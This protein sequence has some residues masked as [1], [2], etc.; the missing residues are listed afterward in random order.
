MKKSLFIMALGAIALTSC[1]QDEIIEVQKDAISFAAITENAGRATI[2]NA[3]NLTEFNVSGIV[4]DG[5][6]YKTYFDKITMDDGTKEGSIYNSGYY[7]PMGNMDFYAYAP[8]ALTFVLGTPDAAANKTADKAAKIT[9]VTIADDATDQADIVYALSTNNA[10]PAAAAAPVDL[11]FRHALSQVD[12]KVKIA[13]NVAQAIKVVVNSITVKNLQ[14]TGV[15]SFPTTKTDT[16]TDG[17]GTWAISGE[18]KDY[19]VAPGWGALTNG[20]TGSTEAVTATAT[21]SMLLLP[22]TIEASTYSSGWSAK[23]LFILDADVYSV[24]GGTEVQLVSEPTYVPV[25]INWEEGKHY[26]YTFVYSAD[27]NGGKTDDNE[28]QLIP[29]QFTLSV[30][31]FAPTTPAETPVPLQ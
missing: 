13:S 14:G 28:D 7:W 6:T 20:A 26:T 15:Y 16:G 2:T 11:N 19:S 18:L 30:D 27:G 5:G 10:K 17:K 24:V 9:G 21:E 29:I 12:F 4:N 25:E 31:D 1:S 3:T 23:G 22:Q 8:T